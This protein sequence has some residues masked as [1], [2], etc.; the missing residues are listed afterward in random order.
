MLFEPYMY[1]KGVS[2]Q[3]H[4][5]ENISTG[6]LVTSLTRFLQR[7]MLMTDNKET[8]IQVVA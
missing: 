2:A 6:L 7:K 5:Y 1:I 4:T 3:V 8:N